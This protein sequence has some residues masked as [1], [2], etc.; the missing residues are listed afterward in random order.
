MLHLSGV[1][2]IFPLCYF[3]KDQEY[4]R[5]IYKMKE[6]TLLQTENVKTFTLR[7]YTMLKFALVWKQGNRLHIFTI[8][9][10]LLMLRHKIIISL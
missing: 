3:R 9:C 5:N 2:C 1:D 7:Y 10:S 6:E 4:L 8:Y